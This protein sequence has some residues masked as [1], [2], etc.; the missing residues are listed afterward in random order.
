M[1]I[2]ARPT[3]TTHHRTLSSPPP[4]H[5]P[6][7]SRSLDPCPKKLHYVSPAVKD[8]L[9][10][11]FR[12]QLKVIGAGVKVLERQDSKVGAPLSQLCIS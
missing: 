10:L 4:P 5:T 1:I 12:E 2:S 7:V 8:L 3:F 6:Q 11:D 9:R